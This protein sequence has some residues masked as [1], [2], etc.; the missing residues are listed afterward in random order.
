MG[1]FST[2]SQ[3]LT[4]FIEIFPCLTPK[5]MFSGNFLSKRQ[6]GRVLA[7]SLSI[8]Q[9]TKNITCPSDL[10]NTRLYP[11]GSGDASPCMN[12]L[13]TKCNLTSNWECCSDHPHDIHA[14]YMCAHGLSQ[15]GLWVPFWTPKPLKRTPQDTH[16]FSVEFLKIS[17]S[18]L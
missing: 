11:K 13:I 12:T 15:Q 17:I 8:G 1:L 7:K 14:L 2:K 6:A 18:S 10:P 3:S 9:V 4:F 16:F 5:R